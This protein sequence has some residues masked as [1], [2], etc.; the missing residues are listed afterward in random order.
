MQPVSYILK[1][2]ARLAVAPDFFFSHRERRLR[3]RVY[4][5]ARS[6]VSAPQARGPEEAEARRQLMMIDPR[7]ARLQMI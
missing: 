3:M 4:G 1:Q 2:I 5:L 6:W 7:C